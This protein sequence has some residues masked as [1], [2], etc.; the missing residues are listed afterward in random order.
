MELIRHK[1]SKISKRKYRGD[2]SNFPDWKA[3]ILLCAHALRIPW[4]F[5]EPSLQGLMAL[6][7]NAALASDDPALAE[8]FDETKEMYKA[9]IT[10]AFELIVGALGMSG[11]MA[12]VD[13]EWLDN[14]FRDYKSG[15][16]WGDKL[17][18]NIT[19][20]AMKRI[21]TTGAMDRKLAYDDLSWADAADSRALLMERI[22]TKFGACGTASRTSNVFRSF[23]VWTHC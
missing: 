2:Y 17:W 3:E 18:A 9:Q 21:D 14:R 23:L 7:K 11:P 8:Q 5:C 15:Y 22:S 1:A 13:L 4:T 12:T 6:E 20:R 10:E 19:K 16:S